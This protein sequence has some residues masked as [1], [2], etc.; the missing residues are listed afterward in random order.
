VTVAYRAKQIIDGISEHAIKDGA[1]VVEGGRIVSVDPEEDIP[2]GAEEVDLGDATLMPGLVDA[3]VRLVWSA[4][5]EPH[6]L[7][8]REPQALTVLR[9]ARNALL[10]LHAGVTTAR[11]VGRR[12]GSQ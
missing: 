6:E 4:S 12:R 5:A 7:V 9:C 10:H 1:V 2:S 11:D 8:A 3:H